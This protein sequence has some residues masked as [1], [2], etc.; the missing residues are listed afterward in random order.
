[1]KAYM[2]SQERSLI[3]HAHA[4]KKKK[5]FKLDLNTLQHLEEQLSKMEKGFFQNHELFL[6]KILTC[7][8]I[9]LIVWS[10]RRK[11]RLMKVQV[12]KI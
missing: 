11:R 10:V 2:G 7:F 8:T 4:H 12:I 9:S 5:N 6:E 1:M 3:S